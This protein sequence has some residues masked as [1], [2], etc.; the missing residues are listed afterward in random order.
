[1]PYALCLCLFIHRCV[2]SMSDD[3]FETDFIHAN[4]ITISND[5]KYIFV[6]DLMYQRINVYGKFAFL[7]SF[8]EISF[9]F[10]D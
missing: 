3:W 7:S 1:M 5:L 8:L 9:P 10:K 6:N 2:I 4:G